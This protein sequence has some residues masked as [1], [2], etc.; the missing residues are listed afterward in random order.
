MGLQDFWMGS[1]ELMIPIEE[2]VEVRWTQ[3][4]VYFP[5]ARAKKL[6]PVSMSHKKLQ[7]LWGKGSMLIGNGWNCDGSTEASGAQPEAADGWGYVFATQGR[8]NVNY[9]GSDNRIHELWLL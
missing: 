9:C 1:S 6:I 3:M 7:P 8:Q 4:K 2:K 5:L